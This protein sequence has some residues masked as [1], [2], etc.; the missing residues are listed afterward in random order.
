MQVVKRV[1]VVGGVGSAICA[2]AETVGG[3]AAAGMGLL[4]DNLEVLVFCDLWFAHFD[5]RTLRTDSEMNDDGGLVWP[6]GVVDGCGRRSPEPCLAALSISR[7]ATFRSG[8]RVCFI[9][10]TDCGRDTLII[11]ETTEG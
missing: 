10:T 3:D 4:V 11:R 1:G 2:A 7:I 8:V 5:V 9:A 6:L